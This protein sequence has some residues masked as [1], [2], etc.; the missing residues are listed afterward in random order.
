MLVDEV[1]G[2]LHVWTCGPRSV[3]VNRQVASAQGDGA[4]G[5]E[6]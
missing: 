1:I 3:L 6:R 4:V 5:T 2:G